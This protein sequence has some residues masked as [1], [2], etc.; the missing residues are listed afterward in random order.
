MP[1]TVRQSTGFRRDV[2]RVLRQGFD[3][4]KL[5][6]AVE[7]L[8]SQQPLAEH[9][10]DHSLFGNWKSYRECHLQPDWLLIYRVTEEEL[11]LA[12]TGSHAELFS[13]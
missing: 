11:Q 13:R 1:L 2:K 5:E 9:Y 4:S 3:L 7:A 12:R 8:V 6:A 10:R